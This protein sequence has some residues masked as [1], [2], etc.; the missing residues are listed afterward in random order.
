MIW[1]QKSV[2]EA[3]DEDEVGLFPAILMCKE[4]PL[5]QESM[6][7]YDHYKLSLREYKMY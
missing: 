3:L 5:V 1:I 4:N 2:Y 6:I 7:Y